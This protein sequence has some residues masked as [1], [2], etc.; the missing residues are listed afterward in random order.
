MVKPNPENPDVRGAAWKSTIVE[1]LGECPKMG[2]MRPKPLLKV[3]KTRY[4]F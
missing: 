3:W 4:V 2:R 1:K